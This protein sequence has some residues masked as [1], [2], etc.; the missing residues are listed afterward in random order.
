MLTFF[1][2]NTLKHE[3]NNKYE[4]KR[5]LSKKEKILLAHIF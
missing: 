2:F 4:K 1:K 5:L 3:Y